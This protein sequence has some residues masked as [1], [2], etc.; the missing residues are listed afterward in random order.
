[1]RWVVV[2]VGLVVGGSAQ[3]ACRMAFVDGQTQQICDSPL[4]VPAVGVLGVAPIP[5]PSIPPIAMPIIPPIGTSSCRQAQVWNGYAYAW[6][7][8]CQ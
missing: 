7:T 6:Q 1:M 5:L 8:L 2:A 4:D 3:A